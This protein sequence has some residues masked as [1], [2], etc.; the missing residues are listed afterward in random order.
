MADIKLN[1]G[2][3]GCDYV[4]EEVIAEIGLGLLE[5]HKQDNPVQQGVGGGDNTNLGQQPLASP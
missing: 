3:P 2:S 1:Y 5:Y 4:A